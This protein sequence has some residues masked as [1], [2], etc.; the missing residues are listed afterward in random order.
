[1]PTRS[2]F[3]NVAVSLEV[4]GWPTREIT[5]KVSQMLRYV[6]LAEKANVL[7]SRLSGGEQQRVA[8]AR[9]LAPDP[10]VLL[11]D[12]PTGNLD[13]ERSMDIMELLSSVSARGT[14]VFVATH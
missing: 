6:G 12:E 5:R 14:T 9:A 7:P 3:D 4:L 2:V 11:A 13:A 8:I 10:A 1:L